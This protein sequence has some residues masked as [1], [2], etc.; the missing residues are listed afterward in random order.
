MNN[1]KSDQVKLREKLIKIESQSRRDNLLFDGIPE[2]PR[3]TK[4]T[5]KECLNAIFN[6]LETRMG[7]QNARDIKIIRCHRVGPPPTGR[8]AGS[9]RPR[10]I[11]IKL[12]WYGDRQRIWEARF[13]LK[14]SNIF[15]NE[16]FPVE[17]NQRRKKLMP[18]LNKAKKELHMEAYMSVD[19]LHLIDSDNKRTV[20]DVNSMHRLPA[21]LDPKYVTTVQ[22]NDCFAFFGELCPLSNFHPAPIRSDRHTFA[23]VE[24]M[25][26]YTKAEKANDQVAM[27]KILEAESPAECK[28]VGDRVRES[29]DWAREKEAV[30]RQALYLKFT[31]NQHLKDFLLQ[32]QTREIAEA[33]P[34]DLFWGTGVGLRRAEVT[35][36]NLWKG[37]NVLGKLLSEIRNGFKQ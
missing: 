7:I 14:N 27:K 4:E 15:V 24:Q 26:Q 22:K 19:K 29:A 28:A 31:Q 8:Y 9:S 34:N 18:I 33:S 10:S 20:I 23:N 35:N 30:M 5:D 11:I 25:Y 17:I 36:V 1:Y 16:D 2:A 37:Q 6:I 32:I 13:K 21:N 12:H 3:G